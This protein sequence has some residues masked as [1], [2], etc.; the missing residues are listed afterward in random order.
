MQ[1]QEISSEL[2]PL[3]F[4]QANEINGGET[5]WYWI[6]YAVG[7]MSHGLLNDTKSAIHGTYKQSA[8]SKA[9]HSALG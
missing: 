4:E 1:L 7:T 5:L 9:M 2:Q 8:G 3:T 6:F